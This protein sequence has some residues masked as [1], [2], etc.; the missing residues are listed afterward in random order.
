MKRIQIN[1]DVLK[2]SLKPVYENHI[3][4]YT[5]VA[6]LETV[7]A[8]KSPQPQPPPPPPPIYTPPFMPIQNLDEVVQAKGLQAAVY[9]TAN[10]SFTEATGS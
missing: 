7:P 6:H 1:Y 10:W 3:S 4:I 2:L 9:G 5:A 8:Y